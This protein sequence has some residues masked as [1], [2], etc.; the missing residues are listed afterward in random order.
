MVTYMN[1]AVSGGE[2]IFPEAGPSVSSRKGNAVYFEHGHS[3]RQVDPKSL[4]AGAPV[5]QGYK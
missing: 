5:A 3:H 1:D 2:T 4:H